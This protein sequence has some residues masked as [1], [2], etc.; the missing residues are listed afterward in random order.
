[1]SYATEQDVLARAEM[2]SVEA[3]EERLRLAIEDASEFIDG[4]LAGL[5]A[6]PLV[7]PPG[8]LKGMAID[9]AIYN[10][11]R[12]GAGL[13]EDIRKRYEDA[14]SYLRAVG[15][16]NIQLPGQGALDGQKEPGSAYFFSNRRVMGRN[17]M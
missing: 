10:L 3:N 16:G 4:H 1:M 11:M 6:L 9:I 14:Q 7:H 17:R 15:K 5:Y 8:V 2:V 13:T 12:D